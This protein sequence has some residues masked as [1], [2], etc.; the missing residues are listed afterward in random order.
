MKIIPSLLFLLSSVAALI[1]EE[2][3]KVKEK[4]LNKSL[5]KNLYFALKFLKIKDKM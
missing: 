1:E 5:G 4:L 3:E 2:E